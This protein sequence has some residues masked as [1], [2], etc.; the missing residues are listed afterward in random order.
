MRSQ[1]FE[2]PDQTSRVLAVS[3]SETSPFD[4]STL[5]VVPVQFKNL[6][7]PIVIRPAEES[8]GPSVVRLFQSHLNWINV[9]YPPEAVFHRLI[10]TEGMI[11]SV[12][13]F[14]AVVAEGEDRII[15]FAITRPLEP[16]MLEI[17]NMYVDDPYRGRGIASAMLRQLEGLIWERG[18]RVIFGTSSAHWYP[19]KGMPTKIFR[20]GGY[21]ISEIDD[22]LEMYIK[23]RPDRKRLTL[24]PTS[25]GLPEIQR[26]EYL[27]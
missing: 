9:N 23:P 11:Y 2:L 18:Y 7:E 4:E 16:F 20:N 21:E 27:R 5:E 8:D 3:I 19:D 6:D 17:R 13:E 22:G 10:P 14:P 1:D 15:G 12:R 26:F 25:N 24:T